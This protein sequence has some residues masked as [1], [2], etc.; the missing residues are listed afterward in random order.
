MT[1]DV[2]EWFSRNTLIWISWL[3]L[4]VSI[5]YTAKRNS[6]SIFYKPNYL[7]QVHLEER[8]L[9]ILPEHSRLHLHTLWFLHVSKV[10]FL[11]DYLLLHPKVPLQTPTWPRLVYLLDDMAA[12]ERLNRTLPFDIWN[13]YIDISMKPEMMYW[14]TLD[15]LELNFSSIYYSIFFK[16]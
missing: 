14:A 4:Y 6:K 11:L 12:E 2:P 15:T 8:Y 7:R 16:M 9:K 1:S 13:R 3:W 5:T 10:D